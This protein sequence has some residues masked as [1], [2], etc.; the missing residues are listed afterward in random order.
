MPTTPAAP[1]LGPIEP[2][3]D[4][5]YEIHLVVLGSVEDDQRATL[6]QLVLTAAASDAERTT[7]SRTPRYYSTGAVT[8]DVWALRALVD[9]LELAQA[10]GALPPLA[11]QAYACPRWA[12]YGTVVMHTPDLGTFEGRCD[13]QGE[14]VLSGTDVATALSSAG[15]DPAAALSHLAGLPW[16]TALGLLGTPAAAA[17]DT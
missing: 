14:V 13:F 9:S 6:D 7:S 15:Q 4:H 11:Y 17:A 1:P 10:E 12:Q 3:T 2:P 5:R 8:S 16:S